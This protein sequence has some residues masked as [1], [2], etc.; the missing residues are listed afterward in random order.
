MDYKLYF[1]TDFSNVNTT[2]DNIDVCVELSNGRQYTLV[3]STPQNLQHLI[4]NS[5]KSYLE[6]SAP[7]LFVD[8]LTEE[9]IRLLVDE[10]VKNPILL[11]IYGEDLFYD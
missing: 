2:N 6:P 4:S 5:G 9:N 11:R 3:V 8:R 7:F 1:P 10:L